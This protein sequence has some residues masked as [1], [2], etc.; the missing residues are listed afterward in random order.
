MRTYLL[1]QQ[2]YDQITKE[3]RQARLA[4]CGIASK[5]QHA[6]KAFRHINLAEFLLEGIRAATPDGPD[7]A[8]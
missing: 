6:A 1:A 2:T 8:A 7:R 5:N 4:L 3:I